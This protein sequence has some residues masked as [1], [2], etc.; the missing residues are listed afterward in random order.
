MALKGGKLCHLLGL[1]VLE[2]NS[3][4]KVFTGGLSELFS[5]ID[6]TCRRQRRDY[7]Y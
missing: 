5:G 1:W 7:G 3:S 4:K 6:C 2:D